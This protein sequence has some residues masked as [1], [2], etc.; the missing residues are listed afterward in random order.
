[1]IYQTKVPEAGWNGTY[2]GGLQPGDV[3]VYL[4]RYKNARGIQK[5]VKGT[6]ALI[7]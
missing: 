2:K 4:V 3:Y 1:M 5:F 6:V 7:R